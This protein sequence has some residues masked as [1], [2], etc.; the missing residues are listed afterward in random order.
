MCATQM[1]L[2]GAL[3]AIL[4]KTIAGHDGQRKVVCADYVATLTL[5]M[6]SQGHF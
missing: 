5:V 3:F 6:V 2:N 1:G 4:M